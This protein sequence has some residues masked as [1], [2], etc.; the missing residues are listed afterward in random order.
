MKLALALSERADIQ[1]RICSIATR[2][3]RNAK[4][5]AGEKP[6]EDPII[7][8]DEMDNLYE[9]LEVLISKINH[10]NNVTKCG[11][12]TLTDLLAKRDCL[13]GKI[14]KYRSFISEASTL[15]T[16]R[17]TKNEVKIYSSVN[18]P[19][20]QKKIDML[21]KE[22]RELDEKIQEINWTTELI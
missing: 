10:T 22:F 19:E 2:L 18:I 8:I 6:Y 17:L 21:S 16:S 5:Q 13:K 14:G 1:K 4:V 20:M 15:P 7:L 3:D 11:D 9:K 12:I